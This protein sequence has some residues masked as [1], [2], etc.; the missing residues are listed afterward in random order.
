MIPKVNNQFSGDEFLYRLSSFL[1]KEGELHPE[2]IS[3][4]NSDV[5]YLKTAD[6][7]QYVLKR[8]RKKVSSEQQWDFFEAI[9]EVNI[10]P[11]I[12][13]PNGRRIISGDGYWTLAEYQQGKRLRYTRDADRSAAVQALKSFHEKAEGIHLQAQIKRGSYFFRAGQRLELFKKTHPFFELYGFE[14]LYSDIVQ[15]TALYLERSSAFSWEIREEQEKEQG[16]WMHGDVASHN[17]L[18]SGDQTFLLDFDLLQQTTQ[19]YD[20]IQL[21]QRFLPC[22]NWDPEQLFRYRMVADSDMKPWLYAVG[23]PSD[24][25]REW[26]HQLQ[27]KEKSSLLVYLEKMETNWIERRYFLKKA[28]GMLKL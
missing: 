22:L 27:T 4:I 13:F 2:E 24:V 12:R 25:L 19:L 18:H 20:Y 1:L 16:K 11:F 21:A 17:F 14:N 26:L 8:H 10:I 3:R 7:A 15:Q 9:D 23:I 5:F 28:E 6:S